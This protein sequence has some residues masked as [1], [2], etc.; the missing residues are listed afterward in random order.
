MVLFQRANFESG[1]AGHYPDPPLM[2]SQYGGNH[3]AVMSLVC[4][5]FKIRTEANT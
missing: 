5:L 4:F 1:S 2:G 3:L